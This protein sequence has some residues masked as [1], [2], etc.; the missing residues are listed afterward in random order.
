[1]YIERLGIKQAPNMIEIERD[2]LS[3]CTMNSVMTYSFINQCDV[4]RVFN[5]RNKNRHGA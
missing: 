4:T 3:P 5:C 1:M 2:L